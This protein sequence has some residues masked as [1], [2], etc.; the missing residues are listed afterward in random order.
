MDRIRN[1]GKKTFVT[2]VI[3][4]VAASVFFGVGYPISSILEETGMPKSANIA[5]VCAFSIILNLILHAIKKEKVLIKF[6]GKQI[7]ALALGG[8]MVKWA[9]GFLFMTAYGYLEVEEV[10]LLH[11]LHPSMI[12]IFMTIA[13]KERFTWAKL[14]AVICSVGGA[15]FI[16]GGISTGSAIGI[17]A[18]ILTGVAY[19]TYPVLMQEGPLKGIR[20]ETVILYLD[21]CGML[22]SLV[23]SLCAGSF[24]LPISGTVWAG[25]LAYA[26]TAF[27]AYLC[28][29]ISVKKI[30]ATNAAF[31][32]MFEPIASCITAAIVFG[33]ALTKNLL[34]GGICVMLSVLFCNL[35]NTTGSR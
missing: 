29:G 6:T 9:Q 20:T 27:I 1:N 17:A 3:A 8:L 30:G 34:F 15:L 33:S 25:E 21:L 32:S 7:L 11:F 23:I 24:T 31:G 10:T 12:A 13:F 5:W 2:G 19:G 22:I 14:L 4:I 18:A 28:Y 35:E 26:L 16:T